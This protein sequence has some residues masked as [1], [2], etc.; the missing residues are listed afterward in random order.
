[1]QVVVVTKS[2]PDTAAK[3]EVTADGAVSWGE[4]QMVVNPWDEYSITEAVLLKEKYGV[5][6]TVLTVG[7][8]AHNDALKQGLAIGMD[9]AVRGRVVAFEVRIQRVHLEQSILADGES[10]RVDPDRWRPLIMSFQKF[11]GLAPGELH[12]SALG[13]IPEAMYRS[14][15]VDRARAALCAAAN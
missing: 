7:A 5:K 3:V 15:D 6:T 13:Q 9:E 14:H 12:A 8:E 2:T 4:A 1:M 11:Y 10:S